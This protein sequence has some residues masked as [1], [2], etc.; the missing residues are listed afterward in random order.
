[1]LE[2]LQGALAA[3]SATGKGSAVTSIQWIIA[4][5][6]AGLANASLYR[7]PTEWTL[8]LFGV[9]LVGMLVFFCIVYCIWMKLDPDALRSESYSLRKREIDHGLI[10]DDATG[11]RQ[12]TRRR[13]VIAAGTD[14]LQENR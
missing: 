10:G 4:L 3:R 14:V 5:L 7:A 9:L 1:M 11:L 2:W 8:V 6:I 12:P 13:R